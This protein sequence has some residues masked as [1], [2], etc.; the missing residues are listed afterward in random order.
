MQT[1]LG[2]GGVIA[3]EIAKAL[4]QFTSRI[5]LVSRHPKKVNA[6]DELVTADLLNAQ[7][8]DE[9]VKG[10]SIVYL[11][12]GLPYK[13]SVWE[14]QW[15]IVMQNTINACK[16]HGAKLVFFDNIYMYGKASGWKNEKLPFNPAG[17]KGKV[18]AKIATMLLEEMAKGSLTAMIARAPTF[19]GNTKLSFTS[20]M[21]LEKMAAGKKASWV[22]NDQS[23]NT[24]IYIP[25]AG[26]ATALLGNTPSAYQQTWHLP[27]N[28]NAITGQQFITMA[29]KAFGVSADYTVYKK[30]MVKLVGLFVPVMGES[31]ELLY[32]YE[33]DYLFS[34]EKF[35][36]AFPDF[37]ITS[38]EQGI[39]ETVKAL[40]QGK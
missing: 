25:D 36:K 28:K 11:T 7:Q 34:S 4:P 32:E 9:A 35:E 13:A 18:R 10:S 33:D 1:I 17:R 16:K 26:K 29:A 40:K 5:R 37:P 12:A 23:K 30:W 15:P 3:N 39:E 14:E 8:T 6:T 31:V 38:Y 21:V 19:Y 27:T 2:A 24:I 20:V 22:I